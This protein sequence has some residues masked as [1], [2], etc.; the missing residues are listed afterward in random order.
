M[1]PGS[2]PGVWVWLAGL[3]RGGIGELVQDDDAAEG[4]PVQTLVVGLD[5]LIQDSKQ[6][7]V[8]FVHLF[9]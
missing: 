6:A 5:V 7:P 8:E 9:F 3:W 4:G 2:G 1:G